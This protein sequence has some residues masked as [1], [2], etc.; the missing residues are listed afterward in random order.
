MPSDAGLS[1]GKSYSNQCNSPWVSSIRR[2]K[3]W[4]LRFGDHSF[5]YEWLVTFRR[6]FCKCYTHLYGNQMPFLKV[7]MSKDIFLARLVTLS[8][9][10]YKSTQTAV[11]CNVSIF[12]LFIKVHH[13]TFP[14]LI[15][16][17]VNG[18][19]VDFRVPVYPFC[20]AWP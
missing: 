10:C 18:Y 9:Q 8:C 2:F 12:A 1:V 20:Y 13:V 19:L 15:S 11:Y 17:C 7:L 14:K 3:R 6:I 16:Y 4:F 5:I